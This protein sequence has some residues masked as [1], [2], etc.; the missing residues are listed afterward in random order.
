MN[1]NEAMRAAKRAG[2]TPLWIG[3]FLL[4]AP[5]LAAG[6]APAPSAAGEGGGLRSGDTIDLG[7]RSASVL[8]LDTLPYV[9]NKVTQRFVFDRF[10]DPA[11]EELRLKNRLDDVVATGRNEFEKQLLLME[12]VNAQIEYGDPQAAGKGKVR[13]PREILRLASQEQK[14]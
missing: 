14:L 13:E 7:G 10:G 3:L 2:M 5:A 4:A 1:R 8:W 11:L 12:W 9:N 6:S